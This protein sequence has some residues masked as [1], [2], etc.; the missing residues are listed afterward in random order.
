MVGG[1]CSI[2]SEALWQLDGDELVKLKID[3]R[4]QQFAG[5]A[6]AQSLGEAIEPPGVFGLQSDQLSDGSAPSLRPAGSPRR[7]RLRRRCRGAVTG[8]ALAIARLPFGPAQRALAL[9]LAASGLARARDW[10]RWEFRHVTIIQ[11]V[12]AGVA[13]SA[14]AGGFQLWPRAS[15]VLRITI[16]LRMQAIKATLAS[17]PLARRRW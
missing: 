13:A 17:F 4:L 14:R 16:S 3:D 9:R 6:V 8:L 12:Q 15:M 1:T 10:S 7:S 11:G 5:G 2:A